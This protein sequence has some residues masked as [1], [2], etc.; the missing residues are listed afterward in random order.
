MLALLAAGCTN[1]VALGDSFVA[2]PSIP[3]P[4]SG[5]AGCLR[6]DHNYPHLVAR[7]L[8][9]TALRD[10]SCGGATTANMT[11]PQ[12]TD[13]G[14]NAPQFAGLS[15]AT[16]A[17]SVTIGGNDVN[18]FYIAL[19]CV[20]SKNRGSPCRDR[21]VRGGDDTITDR[22]KAAAPKVAAVL[23][24]IRR[25]AP[26]ATVFVVGY[27]DI[28]PDNGHGCFSRMPFTDG[29][30]PYLRDK[31]K[32]INAMLALIAASRHDVYVDAY[33]GSVG[34]DACTSS[35]VRWVEPVTPTHPAVPLHPNAAGMAA[36]ARMLTNAM[37]HHGF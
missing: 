9:G 2:G 20:A 1:Y 23:D 12:P 35:S 6:S 3:R 27:L 13:A 11:R 4:A 18:Y 25:R 19:T 29:D 26:N 31:E 10:V 34:H 5:P 37:R 30:V 32:Q 17:V 21:Y 14:S 22:I 7:S 28:F 33:G 8:D 24:G 15:H 16:N 36:V